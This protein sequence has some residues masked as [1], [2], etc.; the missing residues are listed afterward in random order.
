MREAA[1]VFGEEHGGAGQAV[2]ADM[3]HRGWLVS[4]GDAPRGASG[5]V[6]S[7]LV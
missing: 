5:N 3:L 6:Q 4:G 7:E 2:V 1:R